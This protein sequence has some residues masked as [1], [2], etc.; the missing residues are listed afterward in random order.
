MKNEAPSRF[1]TVLI[2]FVKSQNEY[3][4]KILEFANHLDEAVNIAQSLPYDIQ[5]ELKQL[6]LSELAA[7]GYI[8]LPFNR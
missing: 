8:T 5:Q 7:N 1:K 6:I 2:E 4:G 3:A